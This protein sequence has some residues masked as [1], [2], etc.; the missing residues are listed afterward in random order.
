M[1]VRQGKALE[2]CRVRQCLCGTSSSTL[3]AHLDHTIAQR[4]DRDEMQKKRK[5]VM[6]GS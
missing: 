2:N 5:E 1:L 3:I 4:S 6:C